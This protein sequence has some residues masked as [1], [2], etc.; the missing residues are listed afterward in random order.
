M[1]N[2]ISKWIVIHINY[3][4]VQLILIKVLNTMGWS[5]PSF[6]VEWDIPCTNIKNSGCLIL[7]HPISIIKSVPSSQH[8]E[9]GEILL[10]HQLFKT[11]IIMKVVVL[12]F[13]SDVC[14]SF[15]SFSAWVVG[16]CTCKHAW[17]ICLQDEIWVLFTHQICLCF[18]L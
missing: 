6:F 3:R 5:C 7:T 12:P 16:G 1:N 2:H 11:L 13:L 18:F 14:F 8:L 4:S 15:F 10:S 17:M 9:Q